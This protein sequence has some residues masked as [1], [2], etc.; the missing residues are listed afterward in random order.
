M[1]PVREAGN[2]DAFEVAED[3]FEAFAAF[4]RARGESI[5]DLAGADTRQDRI[6]IRLLEIIG[7]PVRQAMRVQAEVVRITDLFA[8]R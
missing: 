8:P 6:A 2:D 3:R 7:D 5:P 4:W 1:I